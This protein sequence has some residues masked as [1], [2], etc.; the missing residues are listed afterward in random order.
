MYKITVRNQEPFFVENESGQRLMKMWLGEE[1]YP[2]MPARVVVRGV[3]FHSSDIRSI[4]EV[5]ERATA[6]APAP[7]D[8]RDFY[9][10]RRRILSLSL[11]DRAQMM[12]IPNLVW[13]S[14]TGLPVPPEL[15]ERV[16]DRQLAYFR[17]ENEHCAY[18]NPSVYKDLVPKARANPLSGDMQPISNVLPAAGLRLIQNII[19]ADLIA[20][21]ETAKSV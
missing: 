2:P 9:D 20:A 18:A 10:E 16:A 6:A 3:A 8:D 4:A 17:Y 1:G 14:Q 15:V 19:Q 5:E 7:R 11:E 13:V 12:R 21:N